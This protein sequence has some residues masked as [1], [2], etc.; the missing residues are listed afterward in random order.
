MTKLHH[1]IEEIWKAVPGYKG[2]E[3][4]DYGRVRSLDR[5][6]F[7]ARNGK[8]FWFPYK[9]RVLIQQDNGTGYLSVALR[10]SNRTSR[11]YVHILV[12]EAFL[13]E[14]PTPL[15]E[16]AHNDNN[17]A[18]NNI[19]NLRWATKHE[20]Q[21]DRKCHG[22]YLWGEYCPQSILTVAEV[23]T[24]RKSKTSSRIHLAQNY[25]VSVSTIKA[26]RAGRT[27]KHV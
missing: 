8:Y 22:T 21:E 14:R 17:R 11:L 23:R 26:I 18:H 15:H 9:G 24:I 2:Y 25:G 13:E 16:V 4:S 6:K 3:V 20:N 5:E 27:W 12:A 7:I 1:D 19:E 10:C